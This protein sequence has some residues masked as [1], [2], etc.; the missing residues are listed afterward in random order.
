MSTQT[1]KLDPGSYGDAS[2]TDGPSR[3]HPVADQRVRTALLVLVAALC[4]V[5]LRPGATGGSSGQNWD[6]LATGLAADARGTGDVTSAAGGYLPGT[7]IVLQLQLDGVPRARLDH[8]LT[9]VMRARA[10][11]LS[12]LPGGEGVTWSVTAGSPAPWGRLVRVPRQHVLAPTYWRESAGLAPIVDGTGAAPVP[13]AQATPSTPVE[14]SATSPTSPP[15]ATDTTTPAAT[16]PAASTAAGT[17]AFADPAT[18]KP[19]TGTWAATGANYQQTDQSGFDFIAQYVP[20]VPAT[21]TVSVKI[22]AT[23]ATLGAGL[24]L[25]Q[26]Q[27]G[28]RN[29][30]TLI[31]VSGGSYLRWGAY[32]ATN[33]TYAFAGGTT[34]PGKVA[35][36]EWHTLS[37]TVAADGTKISWDGQE[38]GQAD[39]VPAG[40]LGLVTSVCSADFSAFAVMPS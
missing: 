8:W 28:T 33:G 31:D 7:G 3:V 15:A 18:W 19:L 4:V 27:L 24:L 37:V 38:I 22:R 21:Y 9:D 17:G 34:L 12:H 30:A 23:S 20:A 36:G 11:R 6:A 25:G 35:K 5:L 29:G 39:P 10:A 26:P 16:G 40:H 1:Q 32:D 2:P 13:T 14:P